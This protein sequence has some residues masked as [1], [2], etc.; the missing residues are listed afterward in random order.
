MKQFY[1]VSAAGTRQL[2]K[3]RCLQLLLIFLF[4]SGSHS[5]AQEIEWDKTYGGSGSDTFSSFQQTTDGGFIV[6]GS[7]TSGISGEKT[8]ALK[9]DADLWILKLDAAGNKHW[10]RS[11]GGNLSVR[12]TTVKQTP[13]GG[14]IIGGTTGSGIGGDKTQPSRGEDDYWIVKLDAVGN[15][16][17]DRTF[18][19]SGSEWMISLDITQDGGYILGG[20]SHSN[21]SGDKSENSKGSDDY[22]V[23]KVDANGNKVWDRTL[24]GSSL[25]FMRAIVATRDGGFVI[26]GYSNSGFEG[27]KTEGSRGGS[28]YWIVK[29][30]ANGTKLWDKSYG[31]SGTD[32]LFALCETSDGQII[33][34][35]DSY[36]GING[37]KSQAGF[38]WADYWILKLDAN[39]N[40]VWDKTVGGTGTEG[41]ACVKQTS[42]GGYLLSGLSDSG[43][44]GDKTEASQ[45]GFDYWVVKLDNQG[46]RQWDKTLGGRSSEYSKESLQTTDDGYL[47][48]GYSNSGLGG[49]KTG[50]SRGDYDFWIV[51][52]KPEQ[53]PSPVAC[54]VIDFESSST[55]F[56]SSVNTGAGKVNIF[57]KIRRADGSY[58]AENHAS[59]FDTANPTGDD[60]DLWTPDWGHV[61]IINQDLKPEPNDNPWGGEM[62]LDFSEVGPVTMTSMKALDFD[63]YEG[64]SWV[65][66]YD[67]AGNELYKVP[68]QNLGNMSQQEIN[69]GN[70][71]GVMTLK[72][73]LDGIN[74]HQMLA[75]SGAIDDIRFCVKVKEGPQV[76]AGTDKYLTCAVTEVT[77]DGASSTSGATFSWS[78][79]DGFT[80]SE[81]TPSVNVAGTY[82]LTVTDPATGLAA[83]DDVTIRLDYEAPFARIQNFGDGVLTCN[84]DAVSLTGFT[85]IDNAIY[86]WTGP[87]GFTSN[88]STVSVSLPGTYTLTIINPENGCESTTSIKVTEVYPNLS[89]NAGPDKVLTCKEPTVTLTPISSDIERVIWSTSDGHIVSQ[90]LSSAL[91]DK[92][93]TYIVSGRDPYLGCTITDT[94]LV[95]LDNEAPF[96]RISPSSAFDDYISCDNPTVYLLGY[97]TTANAIYSWTGPNG[98]TSDKDVVGA[99]V[100]GNYTL[101]V[102]DPAT[103]CQA[104][105]SRTVNA[106]FTDISINAGPDKV[107]TCKEP[108]VTLTPT[109][110]EVDDYFWYSSDGGNILSRSVSSVVV[111]KPGTYIVSG[112]KRYTTCTVTDTV[113]VT[114]DTEAPNISAKGGTL[115]S[116]TGTVQ[117]TGA[118]TTE[119]VNYSW[120]GPAG[121]TSTEQNPV[122]S[123]AGEY[124][125]TVTD[126]ENGCAATMTVEVQPQAVTQTSAISQATV[127]PNPIESK[128]AVEFKLHTTG[129]YVVELYDLKGKLIRELKTGHATAGE[130]VNVELDGNGLKGGL[131]IARIVSANDTKTIKVILKK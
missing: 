93:G 109:S 69:L 60:L 40:K 124:T 44:G 16:K 110:I 67:K 121:Y 77:L 15:I 31:G 47:L 63:V 131:Y 51:K 54:N 21:I 43:I 58:A 25:E 27:D 80:S 66:L 42:D 105:I 116:E 55:G 7:S 24:G 33:V 46:N 71:K 100:P 111:D 18:G 30:D 10:D 72:V 56:I 104:S 38:G 103:G 65:Y 90:T 36:S 12:A 49:D 59:I 119:G 3:N 82:T 53:A 81:A 50:Y 2:I 92:P 94:V 45:G 73:V 19:G 101:T 37:D 97:T 114:L 20:S 88:K 39:G 102:T 129:N 123:V 62:T 1:L 115:S 112:R 68:I 8:G 5:Y 70:T 23:V 91:V 35:G 118:S 14:Y 32:L 87:N 6:L 13:D 108:T 75:G 85:N 96:V 89:I 29:L 9:G 130:L 95:T 41:L 79:P 34:G 22:W 11:I 125:L 126:L 61:L 107:L 83:S 48:A 98:F 4:S 76:S 99:S 78:G 57:N 120:T 86:N 17:W 128:G 52:L 117:L 127:F 28:D 64:N 122:V 106:Y 84:N 26:G 74:E 113:V